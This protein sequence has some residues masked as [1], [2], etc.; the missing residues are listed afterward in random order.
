MPGE[1]LFVTPLQTKEP[2]G[3][4]QESEK[5]WEGGAPGCSPQALLPRPPHEGGARSLQSPLNT[6]LWNLEGHRHAIA[7]PSL[8]SEMSSHFGHLKHIFTCH[9]LF[10]SIRG[11]G[12]SV[13]LRIF[14]WLFELILKK[15]NLDIQFHISEVTVISTGGTFSNHSFL[16]II[17]FNLWQPIKIGLFM[18][19]LQWLILSWWADVD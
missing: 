18:P 17:S 9:F 19:F 16:S 2:Q 10:Y 3:H 14:H 8:A 6:I 5:R 7:T 4:R 12:H 11:E 1:G 15:N 13:S